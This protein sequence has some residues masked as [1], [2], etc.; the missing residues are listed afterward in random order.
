MACMVDL[1][2]D[3]LGAL[4][5]SRTKLKP[6]FKIN[7]PCPLI[8]IIPG[9]HYYGVQN[10]SQPTCGLVAALGMM[11]DE[12]RELDGTARL[13]HNDE[14]NNNTEQRDRIKKE[15]AKEL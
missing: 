12:M 8:F 15:K 7:I 9:F 1:D 3:N 11:Y 14:D 6:S 5:I 13:D 10:A 4:W 2:L